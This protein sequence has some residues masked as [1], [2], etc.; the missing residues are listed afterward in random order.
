MSRLQ[1][2]L[3]PICGN[4][5]TVLFRTSGGLSSFSAISSSVRCICSVSDLRSLP[6]QI[7]FV[8]ASCCFSF[9]STVS[10]KY[11]IF[12]ALFCLRA[13]L[14]NHSCQLHSDA[15]ASH[16]PLCVI[17][18]PNS[19]YIARYAPFIWHKSPTNCD[20]HLPE[21]NFQTR[22]GFHNKAFLYYPTIVRTAVTVINV[23]LAVQKN[24]ALCVIFQ[25][26]FLCADAHALIVCAVVFGKP[27]I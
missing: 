12:F 4:K 7:P 8:S 19:G 23:E 16:S 22:S 5:I 14:K 3:C 26:G 17:F 18:A 13:C 11:R 6:L 27:A 24:V 1:C 25:H 21:S 9:G 20:A 2:I 10:C 15:Y